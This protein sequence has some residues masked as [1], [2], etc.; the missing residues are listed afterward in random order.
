M[1]W[2]FS[3]LSLTMLLHSYITGSD[4]FL[5]IVDKKSLQQTK[6]LHSRKKID[7]KKAHKVQGVLPQLMHLGQPLPK[8]QVAFQGMIFSYSLA[9][10]TCPVLRFGGKK[11]RI[12]YIDILQLVI[13]YNLLVIILVSVNKYLA[14][15]K[16]RPQWNLTNDQRY[17]YN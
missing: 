6:S 11:Y 2:P 7:E 14:Y 5:G 10:L 4:S 3:P 8:E 15:W 1:H 17:M 12:E 9:A 13:E 16:S